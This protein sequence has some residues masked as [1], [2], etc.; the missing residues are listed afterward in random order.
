MILIIL[1][2]SFPISNDILYP[3]FFLKDAFLF[4]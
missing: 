1:K 4:G 3:Y 2:I